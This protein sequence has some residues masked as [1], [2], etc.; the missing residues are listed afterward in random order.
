MGHWENNDM[1]YNEI[2]DLV[3]ELYIIEV[4]S[5]E[6]I[7]QKQEL[8]PWTFGFEGIKVIWLLDLR[9]LRDVLFSKD[10]CDDETVH[11]TTITFG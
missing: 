6:E 1:I 11:I 10:L 4:M 9:R 7:R 3:N 8:E 2:F 5:L